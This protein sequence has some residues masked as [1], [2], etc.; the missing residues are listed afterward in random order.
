[1][2]SSTGIQLSSLLKY[3][4]FYGH[5]RVLVLLMLAGVAP[6]VQAQSTTPEQLVQQVINNELVAAKNDHFKWIYRDAYK[7]P[8]KDLV[9]LVV[10]TSE[11]TVS[12]TILMNGHALTPEEREKDRARMRS[13]VHD[14][15][16]R[17]KQRKDSAHDDEQ[18][19]SLMRILPRAFVWTETGESN[20]QI[21]LHFEP[22]PAYQP[23]TYASRVFAA[24]AGDMVINASQKRLAV[25]SGKLVR[26]VE[27]GWGIFGKL[28]QGGTFRVVRSQIAPG[29]W[30][31][32]QT[33]VHIDGHIL[34]FKSISQ[35]EDEISSDY[36][37]TPHG[38]SLEQ[39]AQQL[40]D[41][42]IAKELE[43]SLPH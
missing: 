18:S 39:A 15:S 22:N 35:Q 14:P 1:M 19:A 36:H 4:R 31:I 5:G 33:H 2:F 24:M 13:V 3:P 20:G 26:P 37:P 34:F 8:E 7:S 41:G 11:G 28:Q 21:S 27:F 42:T 43:V 9:K 6:W 10:E 12:Q 23:P 25:L 38:L 40:N 30:Q 17:T 32:T 29:E 16:E